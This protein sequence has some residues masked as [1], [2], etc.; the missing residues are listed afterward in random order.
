MKRLELLLIFLLLVTYRIN[1]QQNYDL[2]NI[3]EEKLVIDSRLVEGHE[4]E[5]RNIL[6]LVIDISLENIVNKDT[7]RTSIPE[8]TYKYQYITVYHDFSF[9]IMR[10]EKYRYVYS[11]IHP[12]AISTGEF[13]GYVRYPDINID[14]EISDIAHVVEILRTIENIEI[15]YE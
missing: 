5:L 9:S 12:D 14:Q 10:S 7:T 15:P 8:Q 11:P 4:S 1:C 3:S 13:K 2:S 6:L